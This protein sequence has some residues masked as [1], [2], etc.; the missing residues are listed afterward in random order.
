MINE[1]PAP[2]PPPPM[3][4]IPIALPIPT[5]SLLSTN[6]TGSTDSLLSLDISDSDETTPQQPQQPKKK[7]RQ[8]KL[9]H[10]GDEALQDMN[11]FTYQAFFKNPVDI[12]KF[13][14]PQL[15]RIAAFQKLHVSGKKT[16]LID[17]ILTF[18]HANVCAM[19]IQKIMRGFFVKRSLQLRGAA[20]K[21]R[22]I[23]VNQSDFY[24]LEP[25]EEISPFE[26]FSYTDS[27]NFTYGFNILSLVSLL[28]RK[29]RG[30]VNPYNRAKIP[31]TI[32]GDVIRLYWYVAILH[33]DVIPE[34]D[35]NDSYMNQYLEPIKLTP[36]LR[37]YYYGF[38]AKMRKLRPLVPRSLE[39][40][41][42]P[43]NTV[44]DASAAAH[45]EGDAAATAVHN[46]DLQIMHMEQMRRKIQE[47]GAR[48]IQERA[49]ELFMEI[50]QLGYY[51][52]NHWFTDLSTNQMFQYYYQLNDIW[53]YQGML[54][55]QMKHRLSPLADPFQNV[56]TI[57][58]HAMHEQITHEDILTECL[59]AMELLIY[60]AFDVEDRKL[61]AML[62]LMGL[63]R[64][65]IPCRQA[66]SW[67][68]DV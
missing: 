7:P 2:T 50:D 30:T 29:G 5:S 44:L 55:M 20:V 51:T 16:V 21:D 17:R 27:S 35:L 56:H 13:T 3:V 14:I 37:G 62:V 26:F 15:K 8:R 65:S 41:V 33:K 6:P 61:G 4:S 31:E 60:T 36:F 38:P 18:Y 43:Q 34:Q 52:D 10:A 40:T 68:Y 53:R 45:I 24:T 32:I 59:Q 54:S 25:L 64:V 9:P 47:L 48:P 66:I 63:T 22:Q 39:L 1:L 11:Q 46:I 12:R 42:S 19:H 67:L 49:T 58:R 28:K 23:C 57:R